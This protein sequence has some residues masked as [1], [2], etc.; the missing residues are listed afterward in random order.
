MGGV[1]QGEIKKNCTEL[2]LSPLVSRMLRMHSSYIF[3][4]S[5]K[6]GKKN[7]GGYGYV[8]VAE[9]RGSTQPNTNKAVR[10]VLP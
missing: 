5:E 6:E 2:E 7:R 4:A 10:W 8:R 1:K 9:G 3:S